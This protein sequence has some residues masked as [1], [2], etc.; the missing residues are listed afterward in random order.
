MD[1]HMIRAR[2]P[3]GLIIQ[4]LIG[5]M[6]DKTWHP[7]YGRRK[8]YFLIGALGCMLILFLFPF[9]TALWMAV[10]ALWLLDASNNT[11]MEPYRAFITDRLPKSQLARGFL[12][13]SM[14]VG[15]GAVLSNLCIFFF[16]RIVDGETEAGAPYWV[17]A[18]FWVR[19]FCSIAS[20]LISVLS[21]DGFPRLRR[22]S[23]SCEHSP[24]V[25]SQL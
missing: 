19:A 15:A 3:T 6:S 2:L 12:T 14:F 22:S 16:Q 4:P 1:T 23:P 11:A 17:F 21:T 7:K 20:V 10:L 24:R 18:A 13:Q 8:P 5:A 25:W 9:V